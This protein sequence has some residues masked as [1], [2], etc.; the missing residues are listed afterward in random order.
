LFL[1]TQ[2]SSTKL[3]T[4]LKFEYPM[5]KT[6]KDGTL[7]RFLNFGHWDLFDIWDL[8]FEISISR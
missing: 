3:Q 1:K 4:N 5:T 8:I 7:F 2:I 6:F